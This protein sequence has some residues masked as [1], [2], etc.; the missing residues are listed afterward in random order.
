MQ[1]IYP[2]PGYRGAK[3]GRP[4]P[5]SPLIDIWFQLSKA[6]D[7]WACEAWP[8]ANGKLLVRP[9]SFTAYLKK[10]K[11]YL[12]DTHAVTPIFA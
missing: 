9:I 4:T 8:S 2:D 6:D 3:L 10:G 12:F 7:D 11:P 1:N 5:F